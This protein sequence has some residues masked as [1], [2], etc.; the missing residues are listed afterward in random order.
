LIS[1][2]DTSILAAI[3]VYPDMDQDEINTYIDKLDQE[4]IVPVARAVAGQISPN[5]LNSQSQQIYDEFMNW[6]N[7]RIDMIRNEEQMARLRR[8]ETRRSNKMLDL[9]NKGLIS[10]ETLILYGI[11]GP[12][13]EREVYLNMTDI[14]KERLW[15]NRMT[16]RFGHN[17]EDR[18]N[19]QPD[20]FKKKIERITH[21]WLKE[22]F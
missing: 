18:L 13:P 5:D 1:P 14:D 8:Q 6:S 11:S 15:I 16:R 10:E 12:L 4:E 9:K 3:K 19:I 2:N 20:F 7:N 17:W 22:G 21:N